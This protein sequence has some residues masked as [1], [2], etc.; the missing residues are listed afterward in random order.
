MGMGE[1][2]ELAERFWQG[3]I[4]SRDLWRPTGKR[5]EVAPGMVFI[6]SWANVT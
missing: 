2:L 3:E 5:E 1:I 6:H 4:P